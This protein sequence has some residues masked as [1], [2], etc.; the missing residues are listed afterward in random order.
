MLISL[1]PLTLLAHLPLSRTLD[2]NWCTKSFPGFRKC[3]ELQQEYQSAGSVEFSCSHDL[4]Q[5]GCLQDVNE[6]PNTVVSV[7]P[8][9]LYHAQRLGGKYKVILA[10]DYNSAVAHTYYR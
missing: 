1:L 7:N 4:A 5:G 6:E 9:K 2:F 8:G 10:E 3:E